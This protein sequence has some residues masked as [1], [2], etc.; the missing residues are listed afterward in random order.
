[1]LARNIQN[2]QLLVNQ[3]LACRSFLLIIYGAS[4]ELFRYKL[5]GNGFAR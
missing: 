3:I 4:Q 2:N 1:V 5:M